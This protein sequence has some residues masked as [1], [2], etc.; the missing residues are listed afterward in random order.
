M[1]ARLFILFASLLLT[2]T[3]IAKVAVNQIELVGDKRTKIDWLKTYLSIDLPIELSESAHATLLG[4]WQRRLLTT[5]VYHGVEVRAEGDTVFFDLKEKWTTIPVIRG[6]FGG[7][8]PLRVFG[9]YDTMSF[10][11]LWTLGSELRQ[12]GNED[13]GYVVWAKAPRYKDG[14]YVLGAEF[15]KDKRVR[16]FFDDSFKP[17]GELQTESNRFR[18]IYLRPHIKLSRSNDFLH[19]LRYG[20]DFQYRRIFPSTARSLTEKEIWQPK[21]LEYS[22]TD[23]DLEVQLQP[24]LVYDDIDQYG[25]I[26]DGFRAI[27]KPGFLRSSK[28]TSPLFES[29]LFIYKDLEHFNLALHSFISGTPLKSLVG[30]KFLGGF[31]TIR[32]IPDGAI[33]GNYSIVQNIEFR[34]II[35][36]MPYLTVQGIGFLDFGAAAESIDHLGNHQAKSL[37][38]GVRL[39]VPQVYRL[40]LR[41]DYA[42]SLDDA[43]VQGFSIGL[44]HFFQPYRP[45]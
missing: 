38:M 43:S 10:G 19:H 20:F 33:Y 36:R 31:D 22:T 35:K 40:N 3:A 45:L 13:P 34:K 39:S 16:T 18:F 15:W 14:R 12:Y 41:I 7:G 9:I 2:G 26:K 1:I 21:R 23:F 5:G 29:E 11:R 17:E 6:E 27:L 25:L 42:R 8:T 28:T 4:N 24:T 32:G 30:Q 37:G 44:N